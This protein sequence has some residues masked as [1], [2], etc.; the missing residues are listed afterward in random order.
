MPKKKDQKKDQLKFKQFVAAAPSEAYS[1]FTNGAAFCEWLCDVAQVDAR[2]DG[3]LYLGWESGYFVN[4]DYLELAPNEKVVFSWHGAGEPGATQVKATFESQPDGTRLVLSHQGIGS[5]DA[6][7]RARKEFKGSWKRALENFKSVLETGQDLRFLNRPRL[8]FCEIQELSAEQ[9]ALAGYARRAGLLVQGV[10]E[11]LCAANAGLQTGDLLVKFAG[12]KTSTLA[13]LGEALHQ[14]EAGDEVKFLFYRGETK[15]SAKAQ[16]S[17]RPALEVPPTAET[18]AEAVSRQYD[19]FGVE[20]DALLKGVSEQMAEYRSDP[21]EW[22][23]KEMLAHLIATEREIQAWTARR[24]EGQEADF[25][26]LANQPVRIR[27]IISTFPSLASLAAELKR[28]QTETVAMAYDL[29][30]DFVRRRRG[31][32][33]VGYK[34][35]QI[36]VWHLQTHL[37]Q[38]RAT[39]ELAGQ[40]P[41]TVTVSGDGK[42]EPV[43]G[44][45]AQA[46]KWYEI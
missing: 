36:S 38:V 1:A 20:L 41:M 24:V 2:L 25:A 30:E 29:P 17:H 13:E 32:W 28:N 8:G 33:R 21:A 27:A 6:W 42:S 11:G 45:E 37:D 23:V 44:T 43:D 5:E 12:Q 10:E 3:H 9:S 46:Q 16:L 22:S 15:M 14:H 18:L 4:G 31:Y 35:L 19:R 7:K 34:V 26:L 39:L 40:S